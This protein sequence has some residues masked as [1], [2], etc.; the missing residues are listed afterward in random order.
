MS[1]KITIEEIYKIIESAITEFNEMQDDEDQLVFE[2][3]TVLFHREGY[4]EKGSLDSLGLVNFLITLDEYLDNDHRT[5]SMNFDINKLLEEK[6]T[7]LK[8]IESLANYIL[9]LQKDE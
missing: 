2:K 9:S 5:V 4:T 8:N 7:T 3:K 6:E 1:N